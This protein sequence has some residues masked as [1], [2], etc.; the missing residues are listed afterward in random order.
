MTPTSMTYDDARA[1]LGDRV[2][3]ESLA[4]ARGRLAPPDL[5]RMQRITEALGRPHTTYPVIHVT[6]T[7]GKTST[8]RAISSL[9]EQMGL[10][11]GL[12]TSPDLGRVNER[13]QRNGAPVSDDD[14]AEALGSVLAAE[15]LVG[16]ERLSWFELVTATAF[17]WFADAPVDIAVVEVGMLGRWDATNVVESQVAVVTNIGLDHTAY[18]GP[19]RSDVAREKAGIVK[20]GSILVQGETDAALA[21]LFEDLGQTETLRRGLDWGWTDNRVAVGGRVLDLY[22]PGARYEEMY[23]P[24]HGA[25]MGDNVAC[26]LAACEAFFGAPLPA[27]VVEAGLAQATSPGRL[28]VVGHQPLVVLDGAHNTEGMEALLTALREGFDVPGRHHV[29]FGALTGHDP[30]DLL[31]I[32]DPARTASVTACAP[33]WARAIAATDI[34]AAAE[35]LGLP[36]TVVPRV[37]DAVSAAVAAARPDDLVLVCGSLYVVAEARRA[38]T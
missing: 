19:T 25:Y 15:Q 30:A 23:V 8:A 6:G 3:Y 11:A 26:A 13:M 12:Y 4:A 24:L 38:L 28:E 32:L 9:L 7:N 29:V 34:A 18:A 1:A 10:V 37:S 35:G 21:A 27:D 36:V 2:N 33:D 31:G 17:V 22:T 14:F 16:G 5:A 20:P